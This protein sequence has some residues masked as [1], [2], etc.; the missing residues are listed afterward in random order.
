MT[1]ARTDGLAYWPV[2]RRDVAS[3]GEGRAGPWG[4]PKDDQEMAPRREPAL[5]VPWPV[6]LLIVV[7]VVAHATRVGL[8]IGP[9]RFALTS[10]NL[11]AGRGIG[12]ITHIFVHA[13]WAHV[14]M[15]SL[16]VLAF[17]TPVS[18]FLGTG[19]RGAA[20]FLALFLVCGVLAGLAYGALIGSLGAAGLGFGAP[21]GGGWAVVGASGAA[22]GLMGAAVRLIQGRGRPGS[23]TGRTV[24]GMT[25]AWILVNALLGLSGMTPGTAGAPVAWE[26]HIFGYF[27]GLLLIGAFARAAGVG[28]DRPFTKR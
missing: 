4:R 14:I 16:F 28:P 12:L 23:L 10:E 5:N 27:A 18:R 25:F 13:N 26:A 1:T 11:A 8:G 19:A 7:L 17:G 22:S 20:T 21:G 9:D 15:N 24:I 3:D 2:T 6:I